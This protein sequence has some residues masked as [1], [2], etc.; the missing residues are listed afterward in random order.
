V[1]V[2]EGD[3]GL[4]LID[5]GWAYPPGRTALGDALAELSYS[6]QDIRSVLVTHVHMDHYSQGAT[7]RR[8]SGCRLAI[9]EGERP[10]LEA[11]HSGV[12]RENQTQIAELRRHGAWPVI[13]ALKAGGYDGPTDAD[14]WE[15]PDEWIRNG[16]LFEVG[17]TTLRAMHTPGH[18][19][20][21]LVYVD[22]DRG[23]LFSGD[24]VLPHIT[25]SI[26]YESR[27]GAL[28]LNSYLS[29]LRAVRKLPDMMM[30]PAHGPVWSSVHSRVEELLA[31]HEQRLDACAALLDGRPRTAYEVA[32]G[33]PWTKRG[34]RFADLNP[35]N[36]M[37]A[38]C[39]TAAHLDV[40]E[41]HGRCVREEAGD[42]VWYHAARAPDDAG[43]GEEPMGAP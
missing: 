12:E 36:Q 38:V 25:P 1:Y 9:G 20:G 29:S 34:R 15:L 41:L 26:G 33:L 4:T 39:E 11:M 32:Q 14:L 21:H 27:V 13:E 23:L 42:V 40:L 6:V 5:A 31:H 10:S 16:Q 28:A 2:V 37:L 8:E 35:L 7:L 43:G 3:D 22:D 30:L 17:K 18:T 19:Q 24:H